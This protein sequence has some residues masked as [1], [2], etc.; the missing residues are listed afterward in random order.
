MWNR[1]KFN[2]VSCNILAIFCVNIID[3]CQ[4]SLNFIT[5]SLMIKKLKFF[6]ILNIFFNRIKES[7]NNNLVSRY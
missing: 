5:N 4:Y 7:L 6:S 3:F 2:I 1:Y